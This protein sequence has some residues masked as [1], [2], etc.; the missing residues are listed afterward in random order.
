MDLYKGTL[1]KVIAILAIITI[2]IAFSITNLVYYCKMYVR[3][4]EYILNVGMTKKKMMINIIFASSNI[5]F[6]LLIAFIVIFMYRKQQRENKI[7]FNFIEVANN[8]IN[9]GLSGKDIFQCQRKAG[10]FEV[11]NSWLEYS[12]P[13]Y[14]C[15]YAEVVEAYRPPP[16]KTLPGSGLQDYAE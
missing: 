6:G 1:W 12:E 7:V 9:E 15:N 16:C 14:L 8:Y 10:K 13:D 11:R 2:L 3:P 5:I 4:K